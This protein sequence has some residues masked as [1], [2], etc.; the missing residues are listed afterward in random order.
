MK[1]RTLLAALILA[2]VAGAA[3]AG[4]IIM[5]EQ[6][7]LKGRQLMV[8]GDTPNLNATGFGNHHASV[9]VRSGT[10][11]VCAEPNFGGFCATLQPNEYLH[12]DTRFNERISSAREVGRPVPQAGPAM[13]GPVAEAGPAMR[14]PAGSIQMFSRPGYRGRS[15]ALDRNMPDLNAV[16]FNDRASSLVVRRGTW[17]LCTDDQ[18]R[19]NCQVFEPGRYGDIGPFAGDIS[20]ARLMSNRER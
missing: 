17:Q 14:G 16:R 8:R 9:L 18:Y 13:R 15:I 10:W 6:P 11:E 4:E 12:L 3:Q 2:T 7:G 1:E 5:Y 19:G 20:S